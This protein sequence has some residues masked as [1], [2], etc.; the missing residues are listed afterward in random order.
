MTPKDHLKRLCVVLS[1]L[2]EAGLKL[3]PT[4]CK[5]VKTSVVYLGHKISKEGILTN[6]HKVEGIKNWPSPVWLLIYEAFWD[7]ILLPSFYKGVCESCPSSLQLDFWG[8]CT[9]KKK[10]ILWMEEC[11]EAFDALKALCTCAPNLA[12]AD[13]TKPFKLHIDTST[14]GLGAILYQEQGG[15]DLVIGYASRALSKGES[16]Y[17]AHKLEFLALKWAATKSFQDYL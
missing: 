6:D 8:Q 11:Q 1:Q 2:Q 13:F 5:F 12:L 7:S 3:Q 15:K 14:T 4:K 16:H 10:K 9:Q 17:P